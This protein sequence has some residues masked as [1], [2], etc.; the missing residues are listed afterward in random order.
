LRKLRYRNSAASPEPSPDRPGLGFDQKE[1]TIGRIGKVT[2]HRYC[3]VATSNRADVPIVELIFQRTGLHRLAA[4]EPPYAFRL[5]LLRTVA[6]LALT[7]VLP[8]NREQEPFE[9]HGLSV[10]HPAQGRAAQ[11]NAVFNR[12]QYEV[13]KKRIAGEITAQQHIEADPATRRLASLGEQCQGHRRG[14]IVS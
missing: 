2:K 6:V 13:A 9:E 5:A 7:C 8:E 4:Q 1:A 12:L 11:G 3:M 14:P 10:Q